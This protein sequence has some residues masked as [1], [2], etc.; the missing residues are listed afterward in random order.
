MRR[1]ER[2][3]LAHYEE[4]V[5]EIASTLSTDNYATAIAV[6]EAPDLI[7]GY[8]D[9]KLRNVDRYRARLH[10]LGFVAEQF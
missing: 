5:R 6:A 7:R 4:L 8:E 1:L 9:V 2:S 3:L 10:E